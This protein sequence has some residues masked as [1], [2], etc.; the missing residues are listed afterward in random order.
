MNRKNF[1]VGKSDY[2]IIDADH[3]EIQTSEFSPITILLTRSKNISELANRYLSAAV[4]SL[5]LKKCRC[6]QAVSNV[7]RYQRDNPIA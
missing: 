5:P 1:D 7:S 3:F 4:L 6:L 2:L